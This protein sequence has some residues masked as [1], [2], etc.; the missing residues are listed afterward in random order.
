MKFLN[1]GKVKDGGCFFGIINDPT[2]HE[3]LINKSEYKQVIEEIR[4]KFIEMNNT[5]SNSRFC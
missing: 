2:E 1:S 5:T 4:E 3:N